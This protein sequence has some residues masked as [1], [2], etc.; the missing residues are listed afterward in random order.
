L[1]QAL[2]GERLSEMAALKRAGCV[3]V[4][5]AA[6]PISDTQVLRRAFEY[7]ASLDLTVFVHPEERWLSG[8]CAHEGAVSARLGL[9]GIPET[10]ET[11]ALSRDLLLV[12]QTGVRAHFCGL[13]T[14]HAVRLLVGARGDG[15]AVTADVAAHQLHLTEMDVADFNANCH[16]RPPLRGARDRE[17]L[18]AGLKNASIAAVCSDHQPHDADAKLAPFA[19]TE[20]GISAVETLL[21]LTLRAGE[22]AGMNL[23]DVVAVL[24]RTPAR[25]LGLDAGTLGVGR[26]ADVCVFDP[27][28]EWLLR[29]ADLVSRGKNTPFIGWELKGRVRWTLLRGEV[30]YE[31]G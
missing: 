20:P 21:P 12:Q 26:A 30:V 3:G 28:A 29:E 23:L 4:S 13:S 22:E 7:A 2:Q 8:G 9:T 6:R 14:A 18:L 19:E 16:V 27:A 5:N 11:I 1:T 17:A 15:L 24:T 10:A 25:I 31:R